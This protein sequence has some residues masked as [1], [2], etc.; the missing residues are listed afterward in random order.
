[1]TTGWQK[2]SIISGEKASRQWNEKRL[3]EDIWLGEV[4]QISTGEI[5]KEYG[6]GHQV[7]L[8]ILKKIASGN[9]KDTYPYS[10][11]AFEYDA[12]REGVKISDGSVWTYSPMDI[13][14]DSAGGNGPKHYVWFCS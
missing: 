1:M 6:L 8:R 10:Q 7:T 3:V 2:Q 14:G 5:S 12:E 11:Y 13:N 4:D 9:T